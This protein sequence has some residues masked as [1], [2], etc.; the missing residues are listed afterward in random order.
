MNNNYNDNDLIYKGYVNNLGN[1]QTGNSST[2]KDNRESVNIVRESLAKIL[3]ANLENSS[4]HNMKQYVYQAVANMPEGSLYVYTLSDFKGLI[5]EVQAGIIEMYL[6]NGTGAGGKQSGGFISGGK[7][8]SIDLL[9]ED[10]GF[11]VKNYNIVKNSIDPINFVDSSATHFISKIDVSERV[12]KMMREIYAF[13]GFNQQ[14]TEAFTDTREKIEQ[15]TEDM[16]NIY[17]LF[18][19]EVM[20]FSQTMDQNSQDTYGLEPIC[21]NTF[22]VIGG[23][24]KVFIP[25]SQIIDCFIKALTAW[26]NKQMSKESLFSISREYTGPRITDKKEWKNLPTIHDVAEKMKIRI[27]YKFD[28]GY[29]LNQVV[30]QN[31]AS[32]SAVAF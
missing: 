31:Q 23:T 26:E 9:I 30:S 29:Y 20:H 21:Y 7:K 2:N 1:N 32:Q 22:F 4:A 27:A 12:R 25:S 3:S 19:N 5:G 8:I 28:V 18:T 24:P 16:E 15:S 6:T 13:N 14:Y 17:S 11:Q 10:A